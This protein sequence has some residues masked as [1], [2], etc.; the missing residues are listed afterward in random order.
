[1][2]S[3]EDAPVWAHGD[4]DGEMGASIMFMDRYNPTQFEIVDSSLALADM[5][6]IRS[7]R[8]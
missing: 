5:G 8:R 4:C 1:M 7:C 6:V 2:Q 3:S